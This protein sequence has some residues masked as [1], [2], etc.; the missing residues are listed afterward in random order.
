MSEDI[1]AMVAE[2][3]KE[4]MPAKAETPPSTEGNGTGLIEGAA[5]AGILDKLPSIEI[6][7]LPL[8]DAA[9]GGLAAGVADALSGVVEAFVSL[10][11]WAG[12]AV[13]AYLVNSKM[14]KGFLGSRAA[15]TAALLLTFDAVQG[16]FNFRATTRNIVGGIVGPIVRRSPPQALGPAG[17]AVTGKVARTGDIFVSDFRKQA[18][19]G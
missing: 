7:G 15:N 14:V 8:A 2:V 12:P 13:G 6:M 4:V 18:L 11:P 17:A 1:K 9:K 16:F 5:A 3:V 10:P 19:G